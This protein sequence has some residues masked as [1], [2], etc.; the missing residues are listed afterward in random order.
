MKKVVQY[1]NLDD[2]DKVITLS[3]SFRLTGLTFLKIK[4]CNIMDDLTKQVLNEVAEPE[5]AETESPT[6]EKTIQK[7]RQKKR[8]P[9]NQN[10][11]KL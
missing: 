6:V 9:A 10:L 1:W 11:K 3:E 2:W 4:V 8:R 5:T 7:F